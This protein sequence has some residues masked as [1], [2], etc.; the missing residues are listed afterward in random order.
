[1]IQAALLL[2]TAATAPPASIGAEQAERAFAA[3]A[4]RDG[5]WSAFRAFAARDGLM[6]APEPVKAQA[7][8]AGRENPPVPVMWWPATAITA[9]D[10]SLA[11]STG[12]WIGATEGG[13]GTFTTV[14]R[15][16]ADGGWKWLLD[17][18]RSTP[19]FVPAGREVAHMSPDCSSRIE[20]TA[21]AQ[22]LAEET[23]LA[24]DRRLAADAVQQREGRMPEKAVRTLALQPQGA[25]IAEGRSD[26]AT[27]AW[28]AHALKGG[29]P[30][31]HDLAVWQWRGADGWRIV[32]Y[33]TIGIE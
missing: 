11:I 31:A 9:C 20:K 26:D 8:L 21:R 2:L 32:L 6:F 15:R 1:M 23:S 19:A 14:W 24:P 5:Q 16:Q 4:Q 18:G 17:H 29:K 10:G 27:L 13:T 30:G 25:L 28:Q 3:M 33:E 7:F 22:R 12:P